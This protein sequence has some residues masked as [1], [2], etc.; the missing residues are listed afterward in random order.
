LLGGCGEEAAESRSFGRAQGGE[1]WVCG[2]PNG[3][4][5]EGGHFDE[6][7]CWW[8]LLLVFDANIHVRAR[9]IEIDVW[10]MAS[11][12][13][14]IEERYRKVV[15]QY[16]DFSSTSNYRNDLER[17]CLCTISVSRWRVRSKPGSGRPRHPMGCRGFSNDVEHFHELVCTYHHLRACRV[18]TAPLRYPLPRAFTFIFEVHIPSAYDLSGLH[19]ASE[20]STA[21]YLHT[22]I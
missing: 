15:Y 18:A 14:R 6:V 8:M 21:T 22:F 16:T 17:L 20:I 12:A 11:F 7:L 3:A 10:M 5:E 4:Q 2:R 13:A 19:L 9:T 1:G